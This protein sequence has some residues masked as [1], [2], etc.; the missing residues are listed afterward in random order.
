MSAVAKDSLRYK[1]CQMKKVAP[2]EIVLSS[3]APHMRIFAGSIGIIA[4]SYALQD[5]Y[6]RSNSSKTVACITTTVY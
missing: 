2:V 4:G 3:T 6:V 1:C 5:T